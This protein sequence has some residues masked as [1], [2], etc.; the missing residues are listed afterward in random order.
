MEE[1][2]YIH[3]QQHLKFVHAYP[4]LEQLIVTA[5][6]DPSFAAELLV[7]PIAALARAAP[8]VQLSPVER[9]LAISVTGA[10]DIYDFAARLYAKVQK[11]QAGNG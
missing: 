4:G 10:S 6:A 3:R 9:A 2:D 7:D 5:L 11:E 8:A 1:Q